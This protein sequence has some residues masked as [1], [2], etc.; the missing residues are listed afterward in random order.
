MTGL[1]NDLAINFV[2]C[3][4]WFL[5]KRPLLLVHAY[6]GY[7]VLSHCN[8]NCAF[9][10]ILRPP[11][12]KIDDLIVCD[13]SA[14]MYKYVLILFCSLIL[15]H[16]TRQMNYKK[17][18]ITSFVACCRWTLTIHSF[19]L[20][21]VQEIVYLFGMKCI[22]HY[23]KFKCQ[24]KQNRIV[25]VATAMTHRRFCSFACGMRIVIFQNAM[26]VLQ[27]MF[28]KIINTLLHDNIT[29]IEITLYIFYIF[30]YE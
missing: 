3:K 6:L 28:W 1:M 18:W 17:V 14:K 9:T 25:F 24:A 2:I 26:M 10:G 5:F 13:T 20:N 8:Y 23:E 7:N 12:T 16:R 11:P 22:H 4:C 29:F 19:C 15:H 21:R 27:N 30:L